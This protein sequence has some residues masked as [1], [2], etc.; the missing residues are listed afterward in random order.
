MSKMEAP[1]SGVKIRMYRQGHGDCFLLAFR[2]ENGEPYYMMI[3]CGYKYGSQID[4]SKSIQD[5]VD[6]IGE[7]TGNHLHSILV[8]TQEE[9]MAAGEGMWRPHPLL[10]EARDLLSAGRLDDA[11]ERLS[12]VL[13]LLDGI[14]ISFMTIVELL[15]VDGLSQY[16]PIFFE[17]RSWDWN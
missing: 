4:K 3:D 1:E 15:N 11:S 7:S 17:R 13:V 2:D 9:A 10:S 16:V 5:H 8:R 14:Q 12:E 6:H